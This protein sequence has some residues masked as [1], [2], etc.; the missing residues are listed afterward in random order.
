MGEEVNAAVTRDVAATLPAETQR[1]AANGD[2]APIPRP[3]N[4]NPDPDAGR[5]PLT[6]TEAVMLAVTLCAAAGIEAEDAVI[7]YAPPRTNAVVLIPSAGLVARIGA[8]TGHR[9]RMRRELATA[10][11]LAGHG[12]AVAEPIQDPPCP[13]LAVVDGRIVTWWRHLPDANH[14]TIPQLCSA[15]RDLHTLPAP[16]ARI[17]L[18][19]FDPLA[20]I[21]ADIEAATGIDEKSR[22]VLQAHLSK[23]AARWYASSWPRRPAV[24]LH[25]D[26]HLGNALS[27]PDGRIHLIDFEDTSLGPWQWDL[28]GPIVFHR[29]GWTDDQTLNIGIEAYGRDPRD[30]TDLDV[31]VHI[32]LLRMTCLYAALTGRVTQLREQ[33]RLRI[34]SLSD[35]SLLSGWWLTVPLADLDDDVS[36]L[37]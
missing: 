24:L 4:M 6:V 10:R 12:I 17:G 26:A 35:E 23:L 18:G 30:E 36:R 15:L 27:T 2:S 1:S 37:S 28:I 7:G 5:A 11:Y 21:P 9:D 29:L 19:P 34:A 22:R 16:P 3:C 32:K 13:Q 8:D 33:V 20:R 25:G 14:A 31:L